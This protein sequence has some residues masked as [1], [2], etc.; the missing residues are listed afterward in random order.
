[1]N[2][3]SSLDSQNPIRLDYFTFDFYQYL[4]I[5][6]LRDFIHKIQ[7]EYKKYIIYLLIFITKYP[8]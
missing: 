2:E 7:L 1:M 3:I 4:S 5:Y 6:F 8:L